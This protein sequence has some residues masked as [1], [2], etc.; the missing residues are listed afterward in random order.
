MTHH[1]FGFAITGLALLFAFMAMGVGFVYGPSI[2]ADS[3]LPGHCPAES[4]TYM[5]KRNQTFVRSFT[6]S[7]GNHRSV[8]AMKDGST[9]GSS[10]EVWYVVD[11][12]GDKNYGGAIMIAPASYITSTKYGGP[13]KTWK[14]VSHRPSM[15][16]DASFLPVVF[17]A[18]PDDGLVDGGST[19]T[20]SPLPSVRLTPQTTDDG[21]AGSRSG[22]TSTTSA[23]D[24]GTSGSQGTS[25]V[26]ANSN[27]SRSSGQTNNLPLQ[28]FDH[29]GSNTAPTI[30]TTAQAVALTPSSK[31]SVFMR[32]L[33]FFRNLF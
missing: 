8:L 26:A 15:D 30:S 20:P 2:T 10:G 14:L 24:S 32:I 16:G 19:A 23:P 28:T 4:T 17:C 11:N 1:R 29:P 3:F 5:V 6:E 33:N 21:N 31:P 18:E 12:Y 22:N 25:N 13:G 7:S 27:N 9:T